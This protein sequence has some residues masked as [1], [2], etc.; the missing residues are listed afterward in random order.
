[1]ATKLYLSAFLLAAFVSLSFVNAVFSGLDE[2]V[3]AL[4]LFDESSGKNAT[5][6]SRNGNHGKLEGGAEWV[7]GKFGGGLSFNGTDAYIEVP[8]SKSLEIAKEITIEFWMFPRALTGDAWNI[9]RKHTEDTYDYEIYT[10][11]DGTTWFDLKA[12]EVNIGAKI[13]GNEMPFEQWT[14]LAFTYDGKNAVV[15]ING[16]VVFEQAIAGE[17]PTSDGTLYIGCRDTTKRY[18]NAI[19][20]ELL[21][22]D[23]ARTPDEIKEHIAKGVVG[24]FPV[25]KAGKLAAKWG[26]LKL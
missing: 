5:D 18:I 20:D 2:H 12:F 25:E 4:W 6:T 17:I 8:N 14:H 9:I 16:D 11:A 26:E 7:A 15:Y 10:D 21:L 24:A 3:M 22:S 1:M 13:G 19:L 23:I